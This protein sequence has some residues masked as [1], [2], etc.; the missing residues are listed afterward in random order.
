MVDE[1][2]VCPSVT[3]EVAVPMNRGLRAHQRA[4][5]RTDGGFTLLEV[6]VSL[7]LTIVVMTATAGFFVRGLAATRLMQQRQSAAGLA[8]HAMEQMRTLPVSKL[9]AVAD[10]PAAPVD[11]ADDPAYRVGNINYAV[12]TEV[13]TCYIRRTDTWNGNNSCGTNGGDDDPMYRV[14]VYVTWTPLGGTACSTTTG[15]CMYVVTTIRDPGGSWVER[16]RELP[17]R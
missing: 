4:S 13:K 17:S 2:P 5:A 3:T 15:S 12:T 6:I 14:N 11:G 16:F 7:M 10:K 9:A 1:D 8:S